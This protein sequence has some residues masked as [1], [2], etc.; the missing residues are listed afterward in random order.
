MPA[1]LLITLTERC[2]IL[3]LLNTKSEEAKCQ[4]AD[5][6]PRRVKTMGSSSM[7][8][9]WK[10]PV[11]GPARSFSVKTTVKLAGEELPVCLPNSASEE[12][13]RSDAGNMLEGESYQVF[14]PLEIFWYLTLVMAPVASRGSC[15]GYWG[16]KSILLKKACIKGEVIKVFPNKAHSPD[17]KEKLLPLARETQLD[18]WVWHAHSI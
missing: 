10:S 13:A 5:K 15:D 3:A 1:G 6:T 7:P 16:E 2:A 18:L 14:I 17:T 12:T 9:P 8:L 4:N 11:W